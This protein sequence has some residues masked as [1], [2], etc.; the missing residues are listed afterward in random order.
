MDTPHLRLAVTTNNLVEVDA[1]FA[2]AKQVVFYDVARDHSEFVDV[3]NFSARRRR[4]RAAARA[5][6]TGAA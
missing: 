5:G 6:Q 1:N 3:V 4:G 2:V